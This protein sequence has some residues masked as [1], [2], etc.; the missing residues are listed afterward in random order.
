MGSSNSWKDSL[1]KIKARISLF[2][3]LLRA[4]NYSVSQNGSV[5]DWIVTD[6]TNAND[7]GEPYTLPLGCTKKQAA[8]RQ[9]DT[10]YF[11]Q[12]A[13]MLLAPTQIGLLVAHEAFYRIAVEA[14]QADSNKVRKLMRSILRLNTPFAELSRNVRSIGIDNRFDFASKDVIV[15]TLINV[16]WRNL[17][18]RGWTE[19]EFF[20]DC[21]AERLESRFYTR[22]KDLL[23]SRGCEYDPTVILVCSAPGSY[24]VMVREIATV[25]PNL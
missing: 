7:S 11:D 8:I 20:G 21:I 17:G 18:Y 6:L 23:V 5:E 3:A 10:I 2:P 22:V 16:A 15:Q 25:C 13:S 19:E 1:D 14:G 9:S 24:A 12:T 4:F